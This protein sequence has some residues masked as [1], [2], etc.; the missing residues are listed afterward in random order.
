[1]KFSTNTHT[2]ALACMF[3]LAVAGISSLTGCGGGGSSA[4]PPPATTLSWSVQQTK[5]FHFTWSDVSGETEYRLMENPDVVSGYT[6]V[7]TIPADSTSYDLVVPLP[8]RVNARYILQSCNSGGCT[9]S[10]VE[11]VSGNLA[12]G[13]GYFK[14]SNLVGWF[15]YSI[16]FSADGSTMAVGSDEDVS[17]GGGVYLF[18]NNA[19]TWTQT[20]YVTASNAELDD[21]FGTSVALS[22]DGSI[23]AVGAYGEDGD[24]A[25]VVGGYNN[26]ASASGA[27]YLF[28]NINDNWTQTKYLKAS[29]AASSDFFGYSVALSPDGV[30]LAVAAIQQNI[31][32]GK[33]YLFSG[34]GST[35]VE[36]TPILTAS[37]AGLNDQFGHAIAL[38]AYGTP[39]TLTLAVGAPLEDGDATGVTTGAIAAEV[40]PVMNSGAVYLFSDSS[41]SWTQDAY[42]KPLVTT[43]SDSFGQS[44]ALSADGTTLAVGAYLEDTSVTD[45]GAAYVFSDGGS[46]WAQTALLKASNPG[47]GDWFGEHLTLSADGNVLAVGAYREDSGATGI[48]GDQGD[49]PTN[50]DFGAVYLFSHD[51]GSWSQKAY[52]KA[53][54]SDAG[55]WFGRS[56][57]L[58]PDGNTL[59]TGA[60]GE[61]ST[62]T[63]INGDQTN[64][65]GAQHGAVYLY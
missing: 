33:V 37:N 4:N 36:N 20:G 41:G 43:I 3:T 60:L 56:V 65:A 22:A 39:S 48:N 27:V 34:S 18:H 26:N 17:G 23:L 24:S 44:V 29:D 10:N 30:T 5:T 13:V 8:K 52:I 59:A 35:W 14:A 42:I 6:R 49:D 12:E 7:A 16:A 25:S 54:N 32:N 38:V 28:N 2:I 11:S 40:S 31:G 15:G 58:S 62:T 19:G 1:M 63:G 9:D 61:L 64:N 55:D 53:S 46:G 45:S 21:L 47:N 51:N 57:A 50:T